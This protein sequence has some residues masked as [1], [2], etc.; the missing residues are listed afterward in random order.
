[1]LKNHFK[2][3]WRSLQKH[4]TSSLINIVG[5]AAGMAIAL[6]IGLFVMDEVNFDHYHTNYPRLAEVLLSQSSPEGTDIQPT[7]ATPVGKGLQDQ[8]GDAFAAMSLVSYPGDHIASVGD[9]QVSS[10]G[11]WAQPDFPNMFS[12]RMVAGSANAFKDP[13]SVL[14]ARSLA[15]ALFGAADPINK[16]IRLDNYLDLKIAGVYDDIPLNSSFSGI[17]VV[18]PWDNPAYSYMN[19]ITDWDNHGCRMFVQLKPGVDLA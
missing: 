6:V 13:S 14:I 16:T 19:K 2:I 3:A 10:A 8:Y 9:K 15:K 5:L 4:R 18:T 11:V 1:M 17:T 12:L 7:V